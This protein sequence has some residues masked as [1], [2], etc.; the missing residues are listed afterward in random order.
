MAAIL[1][2]ET[3]KASSK[4]PRLKRLIS[5]AKLLRL[6]SPSR[7]LCPGTL[8][9]DIWWNEKSFPDGRIYIKLHPFPEGFGNLL[10]FRFIQ[11]V[12]SVLFIVSRIMS[13]ML[14]GA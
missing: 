1:L 14:R 5:R 8:E 13:I 10:R 6:K 2:K 7:L 4:L 12:Y 9:E 11:V 3:T